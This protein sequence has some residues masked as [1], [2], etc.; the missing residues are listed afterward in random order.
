[1]QSLQYLE[2]GGRSDVFNCGYGHGSSVQE[3]VQAV[4]RV[5]GKAMPT[6]RDER[7]AGDPAE[8]VADPGK[9]KRIFGWQPE[10]DAIQTIVSS[11]L[12]WERHRHY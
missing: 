1:V 7:R 10:F 3:I 6:S 4:E 5:S 12:Q 11:A 9:I 2:Q 8:L